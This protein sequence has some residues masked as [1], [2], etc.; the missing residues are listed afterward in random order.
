MLTF[1]KVIKFYFQR[2]SK[3][4]DKLFRFFVYFE[5]LATARAGTGFGGGVA[6][7]GVGMVLLSLWMLRGLAGLLWSDSNFCGLD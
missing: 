1:I 5:I 2:S 7:V 4:P 3:K 6:L